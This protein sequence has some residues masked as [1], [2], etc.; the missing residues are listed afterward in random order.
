MPLPGVGR[1]LQDRYE[2]GVVYRM[3]FDHW[4]VLAGARFARGDPQHRE[5]ANRR[6]GVYASNGALLGVAARSAPARALPDLYCFGAARAVRGLLSRV[7]PAHRPAPRLP[8][9]G[10]PQGPHEQPGRRG[11]PALG[12]SARAAPRQL[13]LL[14]GGE[15]RG[16][17]GPGLGGRRHQARPAHHRRA[18][19]RRA[20]RRGRAA[21][22]ARAVR[23]RPAGVRAEP[24]LGPSRVLQLRDRPPGRGR[25]ADHRLPRARHRRP[26][27]G[28][29]LGLPA[30]PGF[31]SRQRDL[32]GRREG[33]RRHP[34]RGED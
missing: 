15:R 7:L 32:H 31:L 18:G 12:R 20:H 5:W 29:R 9:V 34:R 13:P 16:G 27:R 22:P 11:D 25:G 21:R 10:D 24:R 23:R 6:K 30:D 4:K 14:R 26:P 17:G 2:I 3:N 33:G 1:N 19:A 28:R 8:H